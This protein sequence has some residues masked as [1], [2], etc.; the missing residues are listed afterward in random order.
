MRVFFSSY[1]NIFDI[2]DFAYENFCFKI[3]LVSIEIGADAF[4]KLFRLTN[5]DYLTFFI[6]V[7][8]TSGGVGEIVNNSLQI[9]QPILVFLFGHGQYYVS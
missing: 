9:L 4:F 5:I 1:N 3:R 7:L 6:E 2:A 8:I